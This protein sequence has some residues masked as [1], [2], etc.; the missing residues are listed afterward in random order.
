MKVYHGSNVEIDEID[1]SKCRPYKDF[2]CGFYTTKLERQAWQ[3]AKRR[4]EIEGW[5]E[6]TVTVFEIPDD[7]RTVGELRCKF[8]DEKPTVE[9]AI[10]IK[11][12][13]D[14]RFRDISSAE[15]NT[16]CKYDVVVGPVADDNVGLLIRQFARGTIDAEYLK[17]E[18]DFNKLTNQYAFHTEK[19]LKY[20]RKVG[21]EHDGEAA[22]ND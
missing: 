5:G 19:A 8:F 21:V 16:D 9:W 15:C 10:F 1:L 13:R 3:M 20:L 22:G 17:K 11:N 12:N 7:L 18:F 2:G 4:T 6:P 14:R